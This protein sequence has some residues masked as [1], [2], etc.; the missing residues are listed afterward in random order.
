[1]AF[2]S[3]S[4]VLS[5]LT[6]EEALSGVIQ[7]LEDLGFST[8]SWQPGSVQRTIVTALAWFVADSTSVVQELAANAFD[9]TASGVF[10]DA[11]SRFYGNTRTP[12]SATEGLV[13]LTSTS[14]SESWNAGEIVFS[15][16]ADGSS[17]LFVISEPGS[18]SG[19]ATATFTARAIAAGSSG[20]VPNGPAYFVS[21]LGTVTAEL[22]ADATTG[23]WI[24]R[25]GTDEESDARLR[26]RNALKWS[27]LSYGARRDAY[28]LWALE[29]DPTITRVSVEPTGITPTGAEAEVT[30]TLATAVGAASAAQVAD[31]QAYVDARAPFRDDPTVQAATVLPVTVTMA[32]TIE[33][34][35]TTVADIQA[36]INDY[37]G[38][39]PLGGVEIPGFSGVIRDEMVERVMALEGVKRVNMTAPAADVALSKDEIPSA[40]FSITPVLV[41][42]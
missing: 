33:A 2:P 42:T 40:T 22:V 26:E 23:S 28:A 19:A 13:T 7:Y 29:A 18:I 12:A 14:G 5:G 41:T 15:A 16:S 31:V 8:D 4:S 30:I 17:P 21:P 38:T 20:N 32:P 36:V 35:T 34:G 25:P 1:M 3:V 37:F 27:E 6:R 11:V 39:I 24:T 9:S 10:L